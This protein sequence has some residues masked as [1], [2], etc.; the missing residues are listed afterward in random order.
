[1]SAEITKVVINA[2][3]KKI[4][5]SLDELKSLKQ[6]L[7]GLFGQVVS[8]PVYI[9]RWNWPYTKPWVTYTSNGNAYTAQCNNSV[10]SISSA[11]NSSLSQ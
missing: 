5:F 3:G 4:E 6:L 10:L 1:M 8:Y 11:S 7:D 9:D 2:G